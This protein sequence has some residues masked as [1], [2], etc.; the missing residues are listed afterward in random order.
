MPTYEPTT[1][2]TGPV[3][4]YRAGSGQRIDLNTILRSR[5]KNSKDARRLRKMLIEAQRAQENPGKFH[6]GDGLVGGFLSGFGAAGVKAEEPGWSKGKKVVNAFLGGLAGVDPRAMAAERDADYLDAMHDESKA[7]AAEDKDLF[8]MEM[9]RRAD[10]RLQGDYERRLRKE[11][12]ETSAGKAMMENGVRGGTHWPDSVDPDMITN[13]MGQ[14]LI[15]HAQYEDPMFR[16]NFAAAVNMAAKQYHVKFKT[17]EKKQESGPSGQ[18]GDASPP[19]IA[20]LAELI[21]KCA[22]DTGALTADEARVARGELPT[23]EKTPRTGWPWNRTG[24]DKEFPKEKYP[25]LP[26]EEAENILRESGRRGQATS[27][28]V[29]EGVKTMNEPGAWMKVPRVEGEG[30]NVKPVPAH[31]VP[32]VI[33]RGGSP[34][35]QTEMDSLGLALYTPPQPGVGTAPPAPPPAPIAP[36]MGEGEEMSEI[37]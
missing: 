11:A 17:W 37:E 35:G 31:L 6:M 32:A 34:L 30:Y 9:R 12:K 14:L 19:T 36:E 28:A 21:A 4:R 22:V 5:A 7:E 10:A 2:G 1:T 24:G 26:P 8:N 29:R 16:K 3:P 20:D 13:A 27:R 18:S 23:G 33:D 25:Q 15:G